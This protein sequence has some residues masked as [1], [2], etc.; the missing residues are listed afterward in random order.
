MVCSVIRDAQIMNI[1]KVDKIEILHV[2]FIN[3][4]M[5]NF[6]FTNVCKYS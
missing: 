5:H 6:Y 3:N 1:Y 2:I 4:C